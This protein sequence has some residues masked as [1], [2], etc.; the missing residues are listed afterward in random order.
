MLR[1][2]LCFFLFLISFQL[3]SKK[4]ISRSE[5]FIDDNELLQPEDSLPVDEEGNPKISRKDALKSTFK[6]ISKAENSK[7]HFIDKD[8]KR[9]SNNLAIVEFETKKENSLLADIEYSINQSAFKIY[10]TPI[11]LKQAGKNRIDYKA[12]DR[13]GNIEDTNSI[14]I[15]V[16]VNPPT[17]SVRVD[18]KSF[19]NKDLIYYEPGSYI[20]LHAYDNESGIKDVFVNINN[21][22]YLPID[23]FIEK[24]KEPKLY[25]VQAI[26]LDNVLNKSK[27]YSFNFIVDSLPPVVST[28]V[29]NTVYSNKAPICSSASRISLSATDRDS[30]VKL[31]LYKINQSENWINYGGEFKIPEDISN[32][33]LQYKAID[34]V[35]NESE[36]VTYTCQIDREPPKT[37][38]E[39][40][41]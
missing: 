36:V 5:I 10:T 32:L 26:A 2:I 23:Y 21:E 18:G 41:K 29:S 16:D 37:I 20:S 8:G 15:F 12:I 3:Y 6:L 14:E 33:E 30:G 27:E 34:N 17:L 11:L 39:I 38:L 4:T 22:G 24:F 35:G 1:W 7:I 13:V 19:K 9:Y 31:I 40:K 25:R 28:R